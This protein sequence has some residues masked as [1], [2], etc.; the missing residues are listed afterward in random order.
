[1]FFGKRLKGQTR[2]RGAMI[3]VDGVKT[4]AAIL[5]CLPPK[6]A[7]EMVNAL[8]VQDLPLAEKI[9]AQLFVFDDF[10]YVDDHSMQVLIAKIPRATLSLA[11][12]GIKGACLQ[13]FLANISANAAAMLKEELDFSSGKA[14]AKALP[15]IEKA[16]KGVIDLARQLEA[17]EQIIL[18]YDGFYI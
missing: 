1:M 13:K 12:R 8:Q 17:E 18:T 11:L 10:V 5:N 4:A 7:N 9:Q 2:L 15:E 6:Q 16:R 14:Q 3:A